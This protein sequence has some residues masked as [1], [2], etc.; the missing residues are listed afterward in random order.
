MKGRRNEGIWWINE[1]RNDKGMKEWWMN[2]WLNEGMI[3]EWINE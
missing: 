3:N 1:W 2:E